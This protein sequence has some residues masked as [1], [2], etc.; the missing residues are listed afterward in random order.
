MW[1]RSNL[2]AIAILRVSSHRQK[3]NSSHEVQA[4]DVKEYISEYSLKLVRTFKIVESAKDSGDRKLYREA[5]DY[6]LK[7]KIKHILFYMTDREARNLTDSEQ[8][9]K[10]VRADKLNLHYVHDK[11]VLHR[12]SPE[13]D[14]MMRDFQALQNKQLSRTI[15]MKVMDAMTRKAEDGWFPNNHVPL[16]YMHARRRDEDGRELKRGTII[17]PDINAKTIKQVRREFELRAHG[18]SFDSI[19]QQVTEEGLVDIRKVDQYRANTVEKRLKNPFYYGKFRWQECEYIGKHELIIA[20]ELLSQVQLSF[21]KLYSR[22]KI[23]THGI[24]SG[25]WLRCAT[26]GCS[27]VYDP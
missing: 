10:L 20:P 18:F 14:F 15:S 12:K 24:F 22:R 26:C 1:D 19:R 9:E 8:N 17:V 21:G 3:D 4:S 13:S 7:N 11:K 23:G 25:G 6:A 16:G 5:I 2:K 27:I